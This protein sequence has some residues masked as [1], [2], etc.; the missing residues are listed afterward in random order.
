MGEGEDVLVGVP[1]GELEPGEESVLFM[2]LP[3]FYTDIG[4]CI[5]TIEIL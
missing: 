1:E 3:A 2:D 5:T 4:G